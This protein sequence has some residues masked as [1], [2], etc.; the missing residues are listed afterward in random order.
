LL[1]ARS[2]ERVGMSATGVSRSKMQPG[3]WPA[4]VNDKMKTR[5]SAMAERPARC[6]VSVKMFFYCCSNYA[7]RSPVSL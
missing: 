3:E 7:N 5:S 4:N 6:S 2:D 1:E